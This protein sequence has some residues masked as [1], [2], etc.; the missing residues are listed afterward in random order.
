[1]PLLNNPMKYEL[2]FDYEGLTEIVQQRYD[3]ENSV[4]EDPIEDNILE[5]LSE[6]SGESERYLQDRLESTRKLRE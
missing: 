2:D 4:E 5:A 1:M 3:K 6:F